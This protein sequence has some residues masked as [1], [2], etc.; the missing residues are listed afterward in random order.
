VKLHWFRE[1]VY[2][3]DKLVD[4][5]SVEGWL[6]EGEWAVDIAGKVYPAEVSLQPMYDPRM[7]RIKV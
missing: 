6:E 7:E 3:P 2:L 5:G 4:S 1:E